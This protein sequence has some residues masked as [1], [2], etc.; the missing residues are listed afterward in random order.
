M[1]IG[2]AAAGANAPPRADPA[3]TEVEV[4]E[5]VTP[6]TLLS[7]MRVV[8]NAFTFRINQPFVLDHLARALRP[9]GA[10]YNR[11]QVHAVNIRMRLP[12]VPRISVLI[13]HSGITVVTGPRNDD[14]ANAAVQYTLDLLRKVG[15]DEVKSNA[16]VRRNV[17]ATG[18]IGGA[19]NLR[20]MQE[21]S[22]GMSTYQ[23]AFFPGLT[24]RHS[25]FLPVV[26]SVHS[27]GK[28]VM[29]GS[30][31]RAL[32]RKHAAEI[33]RY[34][35]QF[36]TDIV[37][38]ATK[39]LVV[40]EAASSSSSSSSSSS[41]T[42]RKEPTSNA[43]EPSI[44]VEDALASIALSDG[45]MASRDAASVSA[46]SSPAVKAARPG[47]AFDVATVRGALA[48]VEAEMARAS[49]VSA[50]LAPAPDA[51][52]MVSE[53]DYDRYVSK[54]W[55][56]YSE[57]SR[58]LNQIQLLAAYGRVRDRA[59]EMRTEVF[60]CIADDSSAYDDELLGAIHGAAIACM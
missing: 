29:T 13:F 41:G 56:A 20:R 57:A 1:A 44:S 30:T 21:R 38:A 60:R 23:P 58:G 34:V 45:A 5:P 40:T 52:D 36:R 9:Y 22:S 4:D 37:G 3:A 32:Y 48:A 35:A 42:K 31:N 16:G 43:G 17:V 7:T 10:Q 33:Q 12:G 50:P 49:R 18:N 59:A 46:P 55:Q 47:V 6:C 25:Q 54:R 19:V 11:K 24:L 28:T 53:D 8:N 2:S 51:M 14:D 15:Y 39:P 27:S 26:V